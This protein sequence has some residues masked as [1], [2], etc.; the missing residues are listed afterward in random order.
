[1]VFGLAFGWLDIGLMVRFSVCLV[2]GF[3]EDNDDDE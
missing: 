1:M 3:G 2:V